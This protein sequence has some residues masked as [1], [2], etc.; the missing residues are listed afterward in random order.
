MRDDL[1]AIGY[2]LV[3]LLNGELPWHKT[4]KQFA[5]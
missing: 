1:E 2:I 3:Y 5:Y 4:R